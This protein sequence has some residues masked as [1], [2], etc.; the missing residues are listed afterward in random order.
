MVG[1]ECLTASVAIHQ[2][3]AGDPCKEEQ[4]AQI[5]SN[6]VRTPSR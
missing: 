2:Y 3:L 5:E 4:T 6:N 1:Y